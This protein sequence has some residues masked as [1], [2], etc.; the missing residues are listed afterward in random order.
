MKYK[1]L[2]QNRKVQF[3]Y[4]ILDKY[5][6]GIVLNG[7]EVKAT[8]QGKCGLTGTYVGFQGMYPVIYGMQIDTGNMIFY[9]QKNSTR[10]NSLLNNKLNRIEHTIDNKRIR[11][12]LLHKKEIKKLMGRVQEEGISILPLNVYSSES[13]YI[14]LC[15]AVCK[16]KKLHDKRR[17]L[18]ERD[19][20]RDIERDLT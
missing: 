11:Y 17:V 10:H 12:L 20:A 15:L 18:K 6:A 3:E 8:R 7:N 1:I 13:G 19:I 4:T 9:K 2:A 5:E 16:G 14:K